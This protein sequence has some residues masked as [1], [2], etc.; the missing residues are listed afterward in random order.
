MAGLYWVAFALTVDIAKFFWLIPF[1]VL[2]LPM[3]LALFPAILAAV[4]QPLLQRLTVVGRIM[5]F[6]VFWWGQEWLRGHLFTG[7]PWN[8]LGYAWSENVIL[9]LPARYIGTYGL[10]FLAA[11][12]AACLAL[13]YFLPVANKS[14]RRGGIALGI[15]LIVTWFGIGIW[16][17]QQSQPNS[18]TIQVRLVQ[19]NVAQA[20]KWQ[21]DTRVETW[22]SLLQMTAT[23]PM[24]DAPAPQIVVWPEAAA[25]AILNEQPEM[26]RQI[27]QALTKA[28]AQYLLAGGIRRAAD[29]QLFNSMVVIDRAG[30]LVQYYDKHH[31]VPFGEF[32]PFRNILP[33]PLVA[34]VFGRD[35]SRGEQGK[36]LHLVL[37]NGTTLKF[38]PL[39][40]Y[41]AIFPGEVVA[42][43]SQPQLLINITDDSWYGP[44]SGPYQHLDIARMRAVEEGLPLVRVAN[45]GISAAFDAQGKA[46]A[47]P[48]KFG[49]TGI[50]DIA[51]P[52]AP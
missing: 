9:R 34:N 51:V 6:P 24:A 5:A 47:E 25:P 15:I 7:F 32:L 44:T 38:N 29:G 31:L 11:V 30:E 28:G 33:I 4:L 1:A 36:T 42:A 14:W 19:P 52:I 18:Q 8:L 35:L 23:S 2:L 39:I 3:G 22:L 27:G 20:V 48:L 37:D 17:A 13:A 40:C 16:L 21:R 26:R 12:I 49:E 45:T 43:D 50:R 10:S 41:E 46:L